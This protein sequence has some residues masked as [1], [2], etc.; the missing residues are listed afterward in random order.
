MRAPAVPYNTTHVDKLDECVS[1]CSSD[2]S[3]CSVFTFTLTKICNFYSYS[4][5]KFISTSSC[6]N[7]TLWQKEVNGYLLY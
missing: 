6:S 5:F 1:M 2:G 3:A 4:S 7:M